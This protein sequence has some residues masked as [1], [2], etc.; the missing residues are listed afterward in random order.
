MTNLRDKK[1][2]I[3]DLG[4]VIIDID[5]NITYERFRKLGFSEK[6]DFLSKYKQ[7]GVFCDFE[8]GKINSEQFIQE[9]KKRMPDEVSSDEIKDAWNALLLN[10]KTERIE[11]ILKLKETHNI[12]VLSNTNELHIDSCENSVPIV[13][14]LRNLFHQVYYSYEMNMSKPHENIFTALLEHANIKAEETL[15]LD[16]GPANIETA[17]RL[18]IESWLIEHPDEWVPRMNALIQ[19]A[20]Y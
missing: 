16:D 19:E 1:N 5:L 9:I 20:G 7:I 11:T 15:F 6:G 17:K 18:G 10:Y 14:N 13:G 4:N 3:F 12:Y 2:I 8:E